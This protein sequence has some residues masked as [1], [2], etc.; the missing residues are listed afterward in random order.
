MISPY[1]QDVKLTEQVLFC[2]LLPIIPVVGYKRLAPESWWNLH[3]LVMH[4][5]PFGDQWSIFVTSARPREYL[6]S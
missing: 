5:F 2:E 3:M 1:H 4:P 6:P